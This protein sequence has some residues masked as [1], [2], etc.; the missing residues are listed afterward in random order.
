[1]S[2]Q[3]TAC[4]ES[5]RVL[6]QTLEI[7]RRCLRLLVFLEVGVLSRSNTCARVDENNKTIISQSVDALDCVVDARWGERYTLAA[8]SKVSEI[9]RVCWTDSDE[10]P[11][12]P[13]SHLFYVEV[14]RS[15]RKNKGR[16][17]DK[18]KFRGVRVPAPRPTAYTLAPDARVSWLLPKVYR[19]GQVLSLLLHT[20]TSK[21][22]IDMFS[23]SCGDDDSDHQMS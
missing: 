5:L 22:S 12:E 9:L 16:L 18:L 17:T 23:R 14:K 3:R 10:D 6:D 1:M 4:G 7:S 2:S 15:R 8:G 21:P 20:H 19:D 13:D 11:V